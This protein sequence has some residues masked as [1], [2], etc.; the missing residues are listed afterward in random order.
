MIVIDRFLNSRLFLKIIKLINKFN[1]L[2]VCLVVF[3]F[4]VFLVKIF[5]LEVF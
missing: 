2:R 3:L 4:E 1:A 5:F